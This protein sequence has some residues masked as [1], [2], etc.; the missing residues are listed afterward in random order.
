MR[1]VVHHQFA[2]GERLA[3][4]AFQTQTLG[5][6]DI[7]VRREKPKNILAGAFGM[8]QCRIGIAQQR[9]HIVAILAQ[10]ADAGTCRRH[11]IAVFDGNRTSQI[12]EQLASQG[13]DRMNA[14]TM[15]DQEAELIAS[16]TAEDIAFPEQLAQ[17]RAHP[18]QH[19]IAC[20]MPES[21]VDP[22]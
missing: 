13:F 21:I 17:A 1:L 19:G 16:Q 22:A 11:D 18:P 9:R 5:H 8:M 20:R 10:Q 4:I 14:R 15:V 3:Q 12:I 7:H 6:P 2:T